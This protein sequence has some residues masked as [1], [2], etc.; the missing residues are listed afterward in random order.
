MTSGITNRPVPSV[1]AVWLK[2]GQA[3]LDVSPW[4][5]TRTP[6]IGAPAVLS[7]VPVTV[8]GSEAY[9]PVS[10]GGGNGGLTMMGPAKA[11]DAQAKDRIT[12]NNNNANRIVLAEEPARR[13]VRLTVHPFPH[14]H[15]LRRHVPTQSA[16][17]RNC[18]A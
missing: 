9:P 2:F 1:T 16:K 15:A 13:E 5:S 10:H 11:A 4:I 18:A 17:P 7:T 3:V 6:G 8:A 12:T 14:V